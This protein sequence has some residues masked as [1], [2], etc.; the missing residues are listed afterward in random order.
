MSAARQIADA[1]F[2]DAWATPAAILVALIDDPT[3]EVLRADLQHV[4]TLHARG[5]LRDGAPTIL[6]RR[7]GL[8]LCNVHG[9]R[10]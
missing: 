6:G 4:R 5:C 9:L 2:A 1:L 10:A 7:V 8:V 3:L